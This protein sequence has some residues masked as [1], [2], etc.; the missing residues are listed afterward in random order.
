M[1]SL[2]AQQ[3]QS[4]TS[5]AKT[6]VDKAVS[7]S[8]SGQPLKTVI[9]DV[10]KAAEA[11]SS[12]DDRRALY[13]FLGSLQEQSG[14][15][16][17]AAQSYAIAAGISANTPQG[18]PAVSAEQLFINAIRCALSAGDFVTAENYLASRVR[19]STDPVIS[20]SVRLYSVWSQLCQAASDSA[21]KEPLETLRGYSSSPVMES[22]RPA[23]LLS[24]WY[25]DGDQKSAD[26]LLKDYPQSPEAAIV[27]GK[28]AMLPAPFWFFFP[29]KGEAVAA[30]KAEMPPEAAI[31]GN[32]G[33]RAARQQVG[34]FRGETNAKQL[35]SELAARGFKGDIQTETRSSGVTYYIVSVAENARG[36]VGP[37]LRAA[38]Y[39]CYPV[40]E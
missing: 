28:A 22:V 40:Y 4:A 20:A 6:V 39:D 2:N 21:L 12:V 32:S 30:P 13:A 37:A 34:L 24:L 29:R 10:E 18:M 38:G 31:S 23:A 5:G 14:N 27:S 9:A 26:A 19:S 35:V 17:N 33:T 3:G 16:T 25:L 7:A 36:T 8:D 11:A 1:F 15:Y